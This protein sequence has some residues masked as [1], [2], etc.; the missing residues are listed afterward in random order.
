MARLDWKL[1][2]SE[3]RIRALEKTAR[4]DALLS[5]VSPVVAA[6]FGVIPI[7]RKDGEVIVASFPR[8][9]DQALSLLG[10]IIDAEIE[11]VPFEEK[12]MAHY[13]SKIYL[14]DGKGVNFQ[15]FTN[16]D[17][18]TR[19]NI[20]TLIEE[21]KEAIRGRCHLPADRVVL[22][23]ISFRSFLENLDRPEELA[24]YELGDVNPAYRRSAS[25]VYV[26]SSIDYDDETSLLLRESYSYRGVEFRN[27]FRG[28]AVS[29]LPHVIH[30]S[31][32]QIVSIGSGAEVTFYI[33]D[34][35]ETVA[36]G[37]THTWKMNYYFLSFGNRYRREITI[38]LHEH[39]SWP[40]QAISRL[41]SDLPI[42]PA[43]L[44]RWFGYDWEEDGLKPVA[45]P[46]QAK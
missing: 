11:A 37:D 44:R 15:T 14:Q 29:R 42:R 34:R 38:R 45:R 28:A 2:T 31:E 33:Y 22:C 41:S 1:E 36:P 3:D 18:L 43:D 4:S 5:T 30:P 35:L 23:D 21:K 24:G 32:V 46:R 20:P 40:R 7:R 8:A 9:S 17:F 26:D 13:L 16:A 12:L 10:E 6:S 19:E 39:W 27:G 25:R